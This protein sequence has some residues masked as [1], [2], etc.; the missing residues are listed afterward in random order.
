VAHGGHTINRLDE[1]KALRHLCRYLEPPMSNLPLRLSPATLPPARGYSQLS[2]ARGR[3]FYISGQ[4]SVAADGTLVGAGDFVAQLEQVF[5]NLDTAV[6]EVG[7][8]FADVVKLN[9][10]CVESIPRDQLPHLA[11]VRDRYID[12]ARP[13]ASTF[14]Y[15]AGLVR[16]QWLIEIEAIV[17]LPA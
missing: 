3:L 5:R 8:T 9:Y 1:L 7:G 12:A 4:V 17:A 15:I 2:E 16:E 14:V 13:P 6:R 10:Y 11:R